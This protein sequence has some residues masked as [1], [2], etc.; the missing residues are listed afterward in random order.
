M[1]TRF[2]GISHLQRDVI[3]GYVSVESARRDYGAVID[4]KNLKIDREATEA[5]RKKLKAKWKRDTIFIDQK[6]KPYARR[7]FRI[8]RMDE[9]AK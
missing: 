5:N 4:E 9:Q 8:V 2:T 6:T 1:A 3:N 7:Q